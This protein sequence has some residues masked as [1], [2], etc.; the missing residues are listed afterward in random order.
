MS[1]MLLCHRVLCYFAN[2]YY[3]T[4]PSNIYSCVPLILPTG[5]PPHKLKQQTLFK[6]PF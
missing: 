6:K 3:A 2:E 1:I 4:L 5:F